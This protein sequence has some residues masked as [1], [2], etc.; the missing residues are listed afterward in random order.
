MLVLMSIAYTAQNAIYF[1]GHSFAAFFFAT[2]SNAIGTALSLGISSAFVYDTML[3]LGKEKQYEK[4]QSR[5][6]K[7]YYAGRFLAFAGAFIYLANPRMVF[8]LATIVSFA[9]FCTA[10]YLKEPPREKSIS[11]PF[12]HIK[13]GLG[14]L[15]KHKM[16]WHTVVAFSLIGGICE[17]LSNYY[18]PIMKSAGISVVYFGIIYFIA[19]FF[20]L[21]GSVF[22]RKVRQLIDWKKIMFLYLFITLIATLSFTTNSQFLIIAAIVMSSLSLGLQAVFIVNVINKIVPSTHRA[23][24]LSI[25][26]QMHLIFN[27]ILL[28]AVSVISDKISISIGM[29]LVS[30][31]VVMVSVVFLRLAYKKSA[32][33]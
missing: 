26:T 13:E 8:L 21:L 16:V 7:S 4:A 30:V 31:L 5:V 11:E 1:I 28:I 33:A 24:A 29:I 15:L 10:L 23:I 17:L 14:F 3:S 6:V 9:S 25:Q 27:F 18:Q 20:S 12:H 22:Y 32:L 19:N 2:C